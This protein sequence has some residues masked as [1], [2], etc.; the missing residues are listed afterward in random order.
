MNDALKRHLAGKKIAPILKMLEEKGEG[1]SVTA[2]KLLCVLDYDAEKH[3]LY[4]QMENHPKLLQQLMGYHSFDGFKYYHYHLNKNL[5]KIIGNRLLRCEHCEFL[6][7]YAIVL[8]HI[9][10]N[11]NVHYGL[12]QCAYCKR[13]ELLDPSHQMDAC[14][15]NYLAKYAINEKNTAKL[16]FLD[17]IKDIATTLGVL[18][19]RNDSYGGI[20]KARK[21]Y[22]T[23]DFSYTEFRPSHT[24]KKTINEVVLDKMF[25]KM[26]E[27]LYGGNG[28]SR[29]L[30]SGHDEPQE[31]DVISVPL[32]PVS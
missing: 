31:T 13:M 15:R 21:S 14:Y 18:V 11:H 24:T 20:G 7:P 6:G 19:S 22:L 8:G 26:A 10:T 1:N 32:R 4:E 27:I 5:T 17:V 30:G 2:L 12:K 28:L 23:D 29:L 9:A 3:K 16:E 25:T